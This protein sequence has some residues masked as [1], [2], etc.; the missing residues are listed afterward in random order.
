MAGYFVLNGY[1]GGGAGR[2]AGRQARRDGNVAPSI[3][4]SIRGRRYLDVT[5]EPLSETISRGGR[6]RAE[7]VRVFRGGFS[8][9]TPARL[10]PPS[11]G[12][13]VQG[14]SHV[15]HAGA[16]SEDSRRHSRSRSSREDRAAAGMIF[17][18]DV[19]CEGGGGSSP[20]PPSR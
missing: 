14:V 13:T 5:N 9:I 16:S 2:Q 11:P 7:I 18:F 12:E 3:R 6:E 15:S 10:P 20:T 8:R 19:R 4:G 17:Y 1:G